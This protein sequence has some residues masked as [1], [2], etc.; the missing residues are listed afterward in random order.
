MTSHPISSPAPV[1]ATKKSGAL[2]FLIGTLVA[3]AAIAWLAFTSLD[4]QVYYVTVAEAQADYQRWQHREFRIKGLVVAGSHYVREGTL[5]DHRFTIVEEGR[6]LEVI[7]RGILP[8]TFVDGVEV[9]ALG[10]MQDPQVF[11]ATE[12]MAKCASR[13]EEAAPTATR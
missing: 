11:V 9:V 6:T 3:T 8:D 1:L 13:Y 5:D 2:R 10:R 7:F 12:V 4:A